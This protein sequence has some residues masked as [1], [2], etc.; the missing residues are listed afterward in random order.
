MRHLFVTSD[1]DV[2]GVAENQDFSRIF[3]AW[4][5]ETAV[6]WWQALDANELPE[7]GLDD[8]S[9]AV[10]ETGLN[11]LIGTARPGETGEME[12]VFP[13]GVT[14]DDDDEPL[15]TGYRLGPKGL[16]M[17]ACSHPETGF[18][19][20][21]RVWHFL[22]QD[23][24]KIR[25]LG[26]VLWV[27]QEHYVEVARDHLWIYFLKARQLGETT[28][29]IAY[30]A[31]VM[32]FRTQNA[33]VHLVSRTEELAKRSLLKP[34]KAGLSALPE[35]MRLPVEQDT[36]TIYILDAGKNDRRAAYAYAAKEPGRG[37]TCSHLHLDEWAAMAETSPDLPKD[38][39]A[40]AEPTI[41][42]QGGTVHILTTGVGP[43]GYYADVW[44]N[45]ISETGQLQ[46]SFIKASGSR[47]EYTPEFLAKKKAA[48]ADDAR[49][50][51]EYPE[52]WQDALAGAGETF[53]PS[54]LIDKAAEY[55]RGAAK[56]NFYNTRDKDGN[57]ITKQG[58]E[59]RKGRK[60]RRKYVK[61]WD[62]AGPSER[63]DAV[64]GIVLD[65]TEAVW[66]VVHMEYHE[67]ED[68]PVTAW[69]IEQVHAEYPGTTYIEDNEAG[70][71]VRSFLKIPAE[72]VV[73]H[74][75]TRQSKPAALSETKFALESQELKWN[76]RDPN[77]SILDGEMRFYKLADESIKQDTVMALSIAV[78]YGAEAAVSAQSDGRL[79]GVV[80]V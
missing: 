29:A 55:A 68:Y 7:P 56:A 16:R 77:V 28:I 22:D 78:H 64:V 40:A 3:V 42:K 67:R 53:F 80:R 72:Q 57:P 5:P 25:L 58:Y 39:W 6:Q 52:T 26:E 10:T 70:A 50:A 43:T 61:A 41:S 35:E 47:P 32:R 4:S 45:C 1:G 62:I 27:G 79:L 73:G 65:V 76:P 20:F 36:T 46:A 30:D 48:L 17:I 24:G 66:D 69:R 2:L 34:V 44:R 9:I 71:A 33:R 51:H 37:E 49:F 59:D 63:A 60:K 15:P 11:I 8:G 18:R 21:L 38:V 12:T 54:Y 75:T 13:P 31:W 19:E 23:T 14:E 74:R